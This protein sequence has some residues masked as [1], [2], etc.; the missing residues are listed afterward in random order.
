MP[1]PCAGMF[2][3]ITWRMCKCENN[4]QPTTSSQWVLVLGT[5]TIS[6]FHNFPKLQAGRFMPPSEKHGNLHEDIVE[7]RYSSPVARH[8]SA[9]RVPLRLMRTALSVPRLVAMPLLRR[10]NRLSE[11]MAFRTVVRLAHSGNYGFRRVYL[12]RF[13]SRTLRGVVDLSGLRVLGRDRHPVA[14][15]PRRALDRLLDA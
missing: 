5:S 1:A 14:A 6:Q 9:E 11:R 7:S 2:M 4:Q 3:G 15:T 10:G 8:D 13:A 12:P